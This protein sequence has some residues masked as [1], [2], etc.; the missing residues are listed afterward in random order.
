[1]SPIEDHEDHKEF[2]S[3]GFYLNEYHAYLETEKDLSANTMESYSGDVQQYIDFLIARDITDIKHTSNAVVVSYMLFLEEKNNASSTILR[4]MSSLR[5]Y[6]HYLMAQQWI[7]KDPMMHLKTPK[8]ERKVPS[9]LTFEEATRLLDQPGGS[10][11]KSLRDKAMLE[12]L[13]ATGMR[14]SELISLDEKDLDIKTGYITCGS[15]ARKRNIPITPSAMQ[16]LE[17]YLNHA[18]SQLVQNDGEPALFVNVHGKRM[19]RQGFWKIVKH[20]KETAQIDK[21]ITPHTLRHSFAIHLI[22][23]GTDIRSVQKMLGHSDISTTQIYC[24][25]QR[26]NRKTVSSGSFETHFAGS[27]SGK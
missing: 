25:L 14:V 22:E 12:L 11:P 10:D 17:N 21:D 13:Y 20:Y 5:N 1:M 7:K 24:H 2:L 8:S 6:Y 9:V 3:M 4:K 23:N 18:R 19:T 15:S 26:E 16:H 27:E